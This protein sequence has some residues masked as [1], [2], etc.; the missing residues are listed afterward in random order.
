MEG[1]RY[2]YEKFLLDVIMLIYS[3]EEEED[4]DFE[5]ESGVWVFFGC[6]CEFWFGLI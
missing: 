2:G 6:V 1:L 5:E 4:E 3:S